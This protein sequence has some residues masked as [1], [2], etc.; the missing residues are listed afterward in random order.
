MV[1]FIFIFITNIIFIAFVQHCKM[2]WIAQIY[3][4]KKWPTAER[5]TFIVSLCWFQ[6]SWVKIFDILQFCLFHQLDFRPSYDNVWKIQ[7]S[8]NWTRINVWEREIL[9]IN[10]WNKL[11][12]NKFNRGSI[13]F[14]IPF[15]I[16]EKTLQFLSKKLSS[17]FT[18][19]KC[20][21]DYVITKM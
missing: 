13:Q 17:N 11:L 7:R 16:I 14:K 1:I 6:Y 18:K 3:P 2:T 21:S 9:E 4:H 8:S 5:D 15:F 20:G 12:S 19:S 10:Y